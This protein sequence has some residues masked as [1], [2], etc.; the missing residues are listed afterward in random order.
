AQKRT[1]QRV[2]E[3]AQAQRKSETRLDR[4]EQQV[5]ELRG[6]MLEIR[7]RQ[8]AFSFFGRLISRAEVIELQDVLPTIEPF[9]TNAEYDDLVLLDV[10]IRG[11][12]RPSFSSRVGIEE[13]WLAIEVS[14]VVD[15][16]D[17]E[18]ARRRADLL[19]KAG[20]KVLPVAAGP[21]LTRGA[22]QAALKL[23]VLLQMDGRL[24]YLEQA[25]AE[26]RSG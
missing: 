11:R 15:R 10:L 12:L 17:V 16:N 8:R 21:A 19:Q 25:L 7:Y 22:Q 26:L 3:L 6:D 20:L 23:G 13:V 14:G 1:E 5:G 18:R 24:E 2:E 9:L 4:L